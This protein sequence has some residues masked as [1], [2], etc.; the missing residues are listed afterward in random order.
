MDEEK[1]E[2][3]R[4]LIEGC[5][6]AYHSTEDGEVYHGEDPGDALETIMHYIDE[7]E[8]AIS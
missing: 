3:L 1:R 6:E 2:Y 8:R 5:R 7:M 4:T